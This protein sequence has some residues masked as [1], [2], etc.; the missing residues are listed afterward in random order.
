MA[1]GEGSDQYAWGGVAFVLT[2]L[3]VIAYVVLQGLPAIANILYNGRAWC[4]T[5]LN[6]AGICPSLPGRCCMN[7]L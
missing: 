6:E 5:M 4:E 1:R 7:Q 2:L 3:G